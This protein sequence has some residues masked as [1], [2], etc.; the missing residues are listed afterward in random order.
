MNPRRR[1]GTP[2]P[3]CARSTTSCAH[4]DPSSGTKVPGSSWATTRWSPQHRTRP[5]SRAASPRDGPIPN[6]LDGAEH[7]AYRAVVDRYLTTERVDR[8]EEQCRHHVAAIVDG[9]ARGRPVDAVA[10]LGL[11]YAVRA[12]S[13]WLGW[14]PD[15]EEELVGWVADNH[16]ATR[17]GDRTRTAEV[18]E[19]FDRF[20]RRL[21][22]E[23]RGTSTSDVTAELMGDRVDGRPLTDEEVV[24]ILRNWTAGDL[25]SLAASIGV[26]AHQ[27]ATTPTFQDQVRSH[28]RADDRDAVTAA[29]LEMLRIDDPFVSNRRVTSPH[30]ARRRAPGAG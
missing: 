12:Q 6:A 1:P 18:A 4:A 11:P 20:I 26:I 24:S 21:L 9:L 17:S 29:V 16:A 10:G 25:A 14:A 27:L 7:A 2:P 19:R 15:L 5:H 28:V 23:L 3:T 8:D 30:R 22:D 13:T